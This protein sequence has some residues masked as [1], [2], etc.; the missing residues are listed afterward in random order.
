MIKIPPQ[1]R[2]SQHAASADISV[3]LIEEAL[4]QRGGRF[5]GASFMK[6][7]GG[8]QNANYLVEKNGERMVFRFYATGS[9]TAR[10]EMGLLKFLSNTQIPVPRVIDSFETDGKSVVI[11]EYLQGR[12]LQDALQNPLQQPLP[13]ET[14]RQLGAQLA[15]IHSIEFSRTGFIGPDMK[16]GDQFESF[17]AFLKIFIVKTLSEIKEERL[18]YSVRDR[19][20]RLV[21]ERW[22]LVMETEPQKQL[23]HCDFNPKNILVTSEGEVSGILDWEFCLSGNGL[24]DLGNFFRFLYDYPSD[25]RSV[26]M[27]GYKSIKGSIQPNWYDVALLLDIGNMCSFLERREDY[28]KSFHTARTVIQSTLE[29]FDF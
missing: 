14:F 3:S 22:A 6:L 8:F 9:E 18:D 17:G 1:D 4:S 28:Q 12:Q 29:H 2:Y 16:I 27:E 5:R 10:R 15:K 26:F 24:I 19:L 25:A 20:L 13:A 21:D 23:V 7:S 11:L